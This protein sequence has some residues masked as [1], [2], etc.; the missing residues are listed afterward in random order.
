MKTKIKVEDRKFEISLDDATTLSAQLSYLQNEEV[1]TLQHI[2]YHRRRVHKV[3]MELCTNLINEIGLVEYASMVEG[4]ILSNHNLS[5]QKV[6]NNLEDILCLLAKSII[7]TS[8]SVFVPST[9]EYM[10]IY[11]RFKVVKYWQQCSNGDYELSF[12]KEEVERISAAI[13]AIISRGPDSNP[14]LDRHLESMWLHSASNRRLLAIER[15]YAK[16]IESLLAN[17]GKMISSSH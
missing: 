11:E 14:I 1:V 13:G 4:L 9:P 5:H 17:G 8:T 6:N 12:L 16:A 15:K 10:E 7:H 2:K 3:A